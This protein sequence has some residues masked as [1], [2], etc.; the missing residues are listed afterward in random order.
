MALWEWGSSS[1][2]TQEVILAQSLKLPDNTIPADR[3]YNNSGPKKTATITADLMTLAESQAEEAK[4]G[5]SYTFTL[6]DGSTVTG[7]VTGHSHQY[8]KGSGRYNV[9]LTLII[10]YPFS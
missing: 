1:N 3:I 8:I 7:Y 5:G 9:T 2:T 6:A 10:P 4:L